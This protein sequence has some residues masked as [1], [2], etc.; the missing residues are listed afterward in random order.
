MYMVAHNSCQSITS[1]LEECQRSLAVGLYQKGVVPKVEVDVH[2]HGKQLDS[3][4]EK[5]FAVSSA[6]DLP[7][8]SPLDT[9]RGVCF[10]LGTFI[11]ACQ[12]IHFLY[13][14]GVFDSSS[15]STP[16]SRP[17]RF[18]YSRHWNF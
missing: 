17:V 7:C 5:F 8:L 12:N 11:E 1:S 4:Q 9:P 16:S 2:M 14:T 6:L 15:I 10:L 13:P 18:I 3:L